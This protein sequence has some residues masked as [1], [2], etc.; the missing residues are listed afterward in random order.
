MYIF[1]LWRA[2][3]LFLCALFQRFA[4]SLRAVFPTFFFFSQMLRSS[5]IWS[6]FL[7]IW[8][9]IRRLPT[10][11][12]FF[13]KNWQNAKCAFYDF[14]WTVNH[15]QSHCQRW[16]FDKFRVTNKYCWVLP[17]SLLPQNVGTTLLQISTFHMY[18]ITFLHVM[19]CRGLFV[20]W[21]P[22]KRPLFKTTSTNQQTS[23]TFGTFFSHFCDC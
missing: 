11:D 19:I 21:P 7:D 17:E 3:V 20:T 4:I 2:F 18:N 10:L 8:L 13:Y 22:S 9:K 12:K 5:A 16:V 14:V 6:S 15:I 1:F 23:V